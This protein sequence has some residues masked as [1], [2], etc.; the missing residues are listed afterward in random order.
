MNL[1]NKSINITIHVGNNKM[2][3]ILKTSTRNNHILLHTSSANAMFA[4]CLLLNIFLF[5]P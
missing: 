1:E 3:L 2:P 4:L 5:L